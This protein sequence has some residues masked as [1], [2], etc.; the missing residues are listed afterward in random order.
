M[1]DA[2]SPHQPGSVMRREMAEQPDVLAALVERRA[3]TLEQ[4]RSIAPKHLQGVLLLARGSSDN[5]ALHARYLLELATGRPV[6]LAAPSLWTRYGARTALD[7]WVTVAVSQ[8]GATPEI[9]TAME[10]MRDHGAATVAVTNG[11][12]SA[13][14][15]AAHATVALDAGAERAVPATKTVTASLLALIHIAAALGAVPWGAAE[16]G[17]AAAAVDAVLSDEAPVSRALGQLTQREVLHLGR[18]F[19]LPVALEAALKVKETTLVPSRGYASADFLHGPVAAARASAGVVGYAAT[20]PTYDDVVQAVQRAQEQGAA[21][22]LVTDAEAAER[23]GGMPAL[24]VPTGL[25]EPLVSLPM[26]VRAQQMALQSALAAGLDPDAPVG[27]AKVTIT[28]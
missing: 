20:G 19:T 15:R 3:T 18:G 13:L 17:R 8:S 27:L 16:E 5:A 10:A 11:S 28:R 4:V 2:D 21:V 22:V 12:E 26:I 25:P 9:V 24:T 14:A 1:P 6:A 7:G 23:A